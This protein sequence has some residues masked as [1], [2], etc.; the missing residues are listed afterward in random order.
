MPFKDLSIL[1]PGK[2]TKHLKREMGTFPLES[3]LRGMMNKMVVWQRVWRLW[4]NEDG[5]E[6]GQDWKWKDWIFWHISLLKHKHISRLSWNT[7]APKEY[8]D[9]HPSTLERHR[10][11]KA[12][13]Q[14]P[15][16]DQTSA[17][18]ASNSWKSLWAH[19]W[20]FLSEGEWDW[21]E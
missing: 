19:F 10:M 12:S 20:K 2:T 9:S 15:T 3:R 21:H 17:T 14:R 5:G 11:P 18:K 4:T 13:N 16:F 7:N 8:F 6:W 1:K